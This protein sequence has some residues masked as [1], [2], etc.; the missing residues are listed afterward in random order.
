MTK[1]MDEQTLKALRGSIRKWERVA[2]GEIRDKGPQNCPLCKLFN[3]NDIEGEDCVGWGVVIKAST[4]DCVGCPVMAA[5]G[6][7][8][9]MGTPYEAFLDYGHV[10]L[11]VRTPEARKLAEAEVEFLRSLL[12]ARGR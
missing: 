1:P 7:R 12:P 8:Y 4:K 2:K 3:N 9:C 5:T 10:G 6:L 11:L